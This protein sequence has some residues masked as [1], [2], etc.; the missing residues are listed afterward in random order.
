[1]YGQDKLEIFAGVYGDRPNPVVD[2]EQ[3]ASEWEGFK[4]LIKN[5]YTSK[6]M[7]QMFKLLCT[8]HSLRDMFPQLTKLATIG[9]IIPVS[10]A[11]CERAFSS[12][13]CIKG[14]LR[15]RLKIV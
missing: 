5:S 7:Q 2:T 13:N 6:T 9:A 8:D 11:E 1:M 3:C 12:M 4:M 14:E 10:T 15:N